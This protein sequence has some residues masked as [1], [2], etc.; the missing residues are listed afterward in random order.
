[1]EAI[2]VATASNS[3]TRVLGPVLAALLAGRVGYE[4]I[5]WVN[6]ASFLAVIAAWLLTRV[7]DHPRLAERGSLDAI[8]AAVRY[9]RG[10]AAVWV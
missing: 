7:P 8:R 6:A 3:V 4:W 1:P 5:F 9:V 2:T 10:D